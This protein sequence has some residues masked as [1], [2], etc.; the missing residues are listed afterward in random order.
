MW[1][2]VFLLVVFII[3]LLVYLWP[4]V[5]AGL[6]IWMF[7]FFMSREEGDPKPVRPPKA[8]K[9]KAVKALPA[10]KPAQPWPIQSPPEPSYLPRWT[11]TRRRHAE[12]DTAAGP[13]DRRRLEDRRRSGSRNQTHQGPASQGPGQVH[14]DHDE[15]VEP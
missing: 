5:L 8:V 9:S 1:I 4:F 6:I 10:L 2:P 14:S 3:W 15:A 13:G 12:R 7:V 11:P